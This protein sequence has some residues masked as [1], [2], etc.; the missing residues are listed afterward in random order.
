MTGGKRRENKSWRG[1]GPRGPGRAE[2]CLWREVA[3]SSV[4]A[5]SCLHSRAKHRAR[6]VPMDQSRLGKEQT[7]GSK[8]VLSK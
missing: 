3:R 7:P 2:M 5:V 6:G 1:S 8:K 4:W